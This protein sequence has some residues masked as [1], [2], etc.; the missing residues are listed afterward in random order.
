M[1]PSNIALLG[2]YTYS[3][4]FILPRS[5]WSGLWLD[6]NQVIIRRRSVR[7]LKSGLFFFSERTSGPFTRRAG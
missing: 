2:G 4:D 3:Q 6:T 1:L 5:A 7:V